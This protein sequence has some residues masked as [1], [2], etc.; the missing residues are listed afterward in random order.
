MKVILYG[1]LADAI[2]RE[3]EV[4]T[5]PGATVGDVRRLLQEQFPKALAALA[6]GG[7]RGCIDDQIAGDDIVVP[8]GEDIAFLPLLSGG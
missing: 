2:G 4:V 5:V 1:N 7:V 8:A 6:R 3:V